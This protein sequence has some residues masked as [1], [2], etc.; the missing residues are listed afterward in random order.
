MKKRM[1]QAEEV[2]VE[3]EK[4]KYSTFIGKIFPLLNVPVKFILSPILIR[5]RHRTHGS[6]DIKF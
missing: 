3:G 4:K 2:G 5:K 1:L 6:R